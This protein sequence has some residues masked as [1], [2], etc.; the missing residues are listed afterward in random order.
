MSSI[1]ANPMLILA[2]PAFR[3]SFVLQLRPRSAV[4]IV[5]FAIGTTACNDEDW[6]SNQHEVVL[7]GCHS[8]S[9]GSCTYTD[10]CQSKAAYATEEASSADAGCSVRLRVHCE[11][12]CA[13]SAAAVF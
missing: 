11:S 3:M 2:R 8:I 9:Y 7:N 6:K 13:V 12:G 10:L 4:V 1:R 5:S